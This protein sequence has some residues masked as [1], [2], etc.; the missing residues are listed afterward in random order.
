MPNSIQDH[1][2]I[3]TIKNRLCI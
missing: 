3:A 2:A 1:K